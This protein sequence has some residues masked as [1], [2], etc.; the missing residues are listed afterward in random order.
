M[1]HTNFPNFQDGMTPLHLAAFMNIKHYVH[2]IA[3][4]VKHTARKRVDFN[5]KDIVSTISTF[6]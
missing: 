2:A 1:F 3:Y 6:L 4:S 5:L